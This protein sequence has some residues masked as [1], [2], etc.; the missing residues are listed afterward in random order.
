MF[1]RNQ[2]GSILL[3]VLVTMFAL[4]LVGTALAGLSIHD[5]RQ[6]VRQQKSAEAMYVARGGAEA[7]AAYIM[8]HPEAAESI[9]AKGSAE[10]VVKDGLKFSV[11][12]TASEDGV[13]SVASTG[14]AGDYS[15]KLTFSLLPGP[16]MAVPVEQEFWP[17][18]DMAVFA[19]GKVTVGNSVLIDGNMGT[20][21]IGNGDV[22]LE[23]SGTVDGDVKVGIGGNSSNVVQFKNGAMVT[24]T[25]SNLDEERNYPL[26][27]FPEFPTLPNQ[28]SLSVSSTESVSVAGSYDSID[29]K[30]DGK[31]YFNTDGGDLHIHIKD[32]SLKGKVYVN[33]PGRLFLY[34]DGKFDFGNSVI[35]N[36]GGDPNKVFLYYDGGNPQI[37]FNNNSEFHGSLYARDADIDIANSAQVLGSIFTGGTD[38]KISHSSEAYV[39]VIYAPNAL[40]T[41]HSESIAY[42]AIVC[43]EFKSHKKA[44]LHFQPNIEDIWDLLP[45]IEFDPEEG[46]IIIQQYIKGAWS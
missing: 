30:K 36:D 25:I 27:I 24:G 8:K 3:V 6:T 7:I 2:R 44:E 19:D 15:E 12:V 22:S 13:V 34:V 21:A 4:I 32:F 26:P 41:L 45:D 42:G 16:E 43:K 11:D 23:N 1:A 28:G 31:L 33:G 5:Q 9:L 39:R 29:V 37:K 20:H 10:V 38:V 18:F 46:V 14:H 17:E 35:F 40:V